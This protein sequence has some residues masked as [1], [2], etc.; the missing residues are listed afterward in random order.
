MKLM[1]QTVRSSHG[2]VVI[3]WIILEQ[4]T[5]NDA[6]KILTPAVAQSAVSNKQME[7]IA[8]SFR[9]IKNVSVN[10]IRGPETN[11]TV[12]IASR[13]KDNPKFR[14]WFRLNGRTL[15]AQDAIEFTRLIQMIQE[16]RLW[17]HKGYSRWFEVSPV[18]LALENNL[19]KQLSAQRRLHYSVPKNAPVPAEPPLLIGEQLAMAEDGWIQVNPT[20]QP[21]GFTNSFATLPELCEQEHAEIG[22]NAGY[23]LNMPEELDSVHGVMNDPVGLLMLDG[24][25]LV[26][27]TYTRSTVLIN[28]LG[29]LFIRRIGMHDIDIQL[30]NVNLKSYQIY[31]R[32][33]G[34]KTPVDT[35][36]VELVITN[37]EVVE[38]NE[39]PS[40]LI[41]QNGFVVSL[42][43]DDPQVQQILEILKLNRKIKYQLQ[44]PRSYG[45]IIHAIAAGPQLVDNERLIS[46][47]FFDREPLQEDFK[48]MVLAPT[49]FTHTVSDEHSRAPRSALGIT[50][51]NKILLVAIDDDRRV[52]MDPKERY[53]IGAT[54]GELAAIM[55]DLGCINAINFDGGGSTTLYHDGKIVNQPSDGFPR[56]ISTAMVVK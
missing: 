2:P 31:T 44:L 20:L 6:G 29:Q 35:A 13:N 5:L 33:S 10:G 26:P 42:P 52:K 56:V 22:I 38:M 53:S 19:I 45:T 27:P 15:L 28:Q 25:I 36:K 4:K 40:T 7:Q 14:E 39:I 17:T 41:P 9:R 1:Q 51:E 49:R 43:K 34:T 37:Q 21:I 16:Q 8:A 3:H 11:D 23:F 32:V 48:S 46:P 47:Y 12:F 50:K 24:K 54:L 55:F 30:G 18:N